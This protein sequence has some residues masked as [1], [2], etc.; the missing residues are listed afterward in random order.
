MKWPERYR[1]VALLTVRE[2]VSFFVIV[3]SFLYVLK[4]KISMQIC[5]FEPLKRENGIF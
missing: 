4:K 5:F 1:S 3:I 2:R